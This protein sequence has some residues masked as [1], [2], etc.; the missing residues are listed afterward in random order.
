MSEQRSSKFGQPT[1]MTLDG[2]F[3]DFLPGKPGIS[4]RTETALTPTGDQNTST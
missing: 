3:N 2:G 1:Q 4:L